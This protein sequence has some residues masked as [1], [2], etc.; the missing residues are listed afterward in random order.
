[1]FL[2]R[3]PKE[4]LA[5]DN[6]ASAFFLSATALAFYPLQDSKVL[7]A[8]AI[9]SSASLISLFL[10]AS[11]SS[12]S[13]IYLSNNSLWEIYSSLISV[14]NSFKMLVIAS[15]GPPVF[16]YTSIYVITAIIDLLDLKAK[17]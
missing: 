3:V 4:V 5:L 1:M 2:L 6:P 12:H 16:N 9:A 8:S 17:A 13:T 10:K 15:I 11:S 14:S 7:L